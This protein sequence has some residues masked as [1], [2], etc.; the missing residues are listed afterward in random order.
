MKTREQLIEELQGLNYDVIDG[1]SLEVLLGAGRHL[2]DDEPLCESCRHNMLVIFML[3]EREQVSE[4]A[5]A[6][7]RLEGPVLN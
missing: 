2:S 7:L 4:L 6:I 1:P 5:G 3:H